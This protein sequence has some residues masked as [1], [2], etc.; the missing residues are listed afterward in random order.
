MRVPS[1]R[2]IPSEAT[3]AFEIVLLV[4]QVADHRRKLAHLHVLE[5]QLAVEPLRGRLALGRGELV[6]LRRSQDAKLFQGGVAAERVVEIADGFPGRSR[7][8]RLGR[9]EESSEEIIQSPVLPRQLVRVCYLEIHVP[10]FSRRRSQENGDPVKLSSGL[11]LLVLLLAFGCRHESDPVRATLDRVVKAAQAR[12]VAAVVENLASDYRDAEGQTAAG[13]AET[14]RRVFAAYEIVDV[15][16]SDVEI[17][18][19]PEAA[20]AT[21]RAEFS[22]Q[23]RKLGGLDAFFP[24]AST[25]RFEVRLVP[26]GRRWKVAYAAWEV[27]SR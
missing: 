21:F 4:E 12:D 3:S 17:D 27:V 15:K 19:A 26:E 5:A 1:A 24:S 23:P 22:G 2:E 9:A 14:L 7:V 6:A 10:I 25:Y 11:A 18:R 13:V 8:A 16:L 20:R